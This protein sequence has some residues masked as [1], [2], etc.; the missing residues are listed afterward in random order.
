MA[1]IVRPLDSY[2]LNN[3]LRV[4]IGTTKENNFFMKLLKKFLKKKNE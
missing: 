1:L 4:S 2:G 3:F